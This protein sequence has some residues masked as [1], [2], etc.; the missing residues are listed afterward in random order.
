M[1]RNGLK[2]TGL[3]RN[4]IRSQRCHVNRFVV[5]AVAD[6]VVA[7]LQRAHDLTVFPASAKR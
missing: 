1:E 7:V 4:R 5:D 2:G 3:R 6:D